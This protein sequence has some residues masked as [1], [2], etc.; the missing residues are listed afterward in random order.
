[1][2]SSTLSISSASLPDGAAPTSVTMASALRR[3]PL[4]STYPECLE[5]IPTSAY[6]STRPP[7]GFLVERTLGFPRRSKGTFRFANS[8]G[9][10]RSASG[11]LALATLPRPAIS[12]CAIARHPCDRPQGPSGLRPP[13]T[14]GTKQQEP[15]NKIKPKYH[16]PPH[17]PWRKTV[18]AGH[19]YLAKKPDISTLRLTPMSKGG[20]TQDA[21]EKKNPGTN[22]CIRVLELVEIFQKDP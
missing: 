13:G 5:A 11:W 9:V 10:E 20:R 8:H 18:E 17:H 19:F 22:H 7:I 12:G 1:V 21:P 15:K 4:K 3:A 2:P 16:V 6:P 14:C